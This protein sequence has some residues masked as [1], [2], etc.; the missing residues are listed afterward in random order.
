MTDDPLAYLHA[1]LDAAEA[2]AETARDFDYAQCGVWEA[3][4]PYPAAGGEADGVSR[5]RGNL[6]AEISRDDIFLEAELPWDLIPHM[7]RHNPAA[8][9][10]RIAADRKQLELHA[11]VPNH[12]RFSER[13]CETSGCDGDHSEPP[14]C[15]S[16]RNYAGDPIEAPCPTAKR[17]S[18]KAGAG[19]GRRGEGRQAAR[20]CRRIPPWL[21]V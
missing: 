20:W 1:T 3:R 9:L 8:V 21:P 11:A 13:G 5:P 4:G 18:P 19:R 10:R 2:E 7:A 6:R 12:G 17:S 14:V 16:C 15:R